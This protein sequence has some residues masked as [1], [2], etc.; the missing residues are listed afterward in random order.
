MFMRML[1]GGAIGALAG[2]GANYLCMITGGACPLMRSKV[3]AVILWACIGALLA[4]VK[5]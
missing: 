2:L 4:A 5:R 3:V 1:I